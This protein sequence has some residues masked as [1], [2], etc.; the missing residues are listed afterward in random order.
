MPLTT[1]E[2]AALS[3]RRARIEAAMGDGVMLL[4]AAPERVYSADVHHV[5]RQDSDFEY[6]TGFGEPESI[7]L[8]APGAKHPFVMFVQPHDPERAI[9]V[10]PRAGT[11]GAVE[12]YG[13]DTAFDIADL[14]KELP[15]L[16]APARQ[17]FLPLGRDDALSRRLLDIVRGVQAQR[18]R[19]GTGPTLVRD[20]GEVLGELRLFKDA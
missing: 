9:W 20:V 7:G 15:K 13:A 10:G 8:I 19:T 2:R 12:T 4:A 17:V 1:D 3:A 16:L 5:Y 14:E 18:P 11:D 6:A